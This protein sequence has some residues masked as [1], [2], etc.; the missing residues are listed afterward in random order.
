MINVTENR[1]GNQEWTLATLGA[2]VTGR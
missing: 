2:Q 1:R